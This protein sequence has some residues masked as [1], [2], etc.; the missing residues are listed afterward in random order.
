MTPTPRLYLVRLFKDG[1]ATRYRRSLVSFREVTLFVHSV[2][3]RRFI[4]EFPDLSIYL[5]L[6]GK[7]LFSAL[8]ALQCVIF[9]TMYSYFTV[10]SM[11]LEHAILWV[12]L[13]MSLVVFEVQTNDSTTE[14]SLKA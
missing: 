1:T 11:Y 2:A 7:M 5:C 14:T 4:Y 6:S 10:V 12:G 9:V 3:T 8:N 13:G